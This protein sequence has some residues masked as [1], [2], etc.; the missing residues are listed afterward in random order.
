[1]DMFVVSVIITGNKDN[2]DNSTNNVIFLDREKA[3]SFITSAYNSHIESNNIKERYKCDEE[4]WECEIAHVLYNDGSKVS[5][6]LTQYGYYKD[7][8]YIPMKEIQEIYED[9]VAE[10]AIL[11][12]KSLYL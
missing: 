7:G 6:K 10:D 8:A 2:N 4:Q 9:M 11:E 12:G 5:W 1:M 3:I